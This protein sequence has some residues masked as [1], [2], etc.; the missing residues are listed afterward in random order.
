[1]R[2]P[3]CCMLEIGG[4]QPGDDGGGGRRAADGRRG[5]R[6]EKLRILRVPTASVHL[7][8]PLC[9]PVQSRRGYIWTGLIVLRHHSLTSVSLQSN[10][11]KAFTEYRSSATTFHRVP[12]ERQFVPRASGSDSSKEETGSVSRGSKEKI[13]WKERDRERKR[14]THTE[15]EEI[16][17]PSL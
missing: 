10:Y 2:W 15:R 11:P 3:G 7:P 4:G 17:R 14:H 9:H 16:W 6:R 1:M 8:S 12:I 13:S 5:P